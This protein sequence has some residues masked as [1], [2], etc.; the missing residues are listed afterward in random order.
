MSMK[1][2]N[3][4]NESNS[5]KTREIDIDGRKDRIRGATWMAVC[6]S[7]GAL[8]WILF[9]YLANRPIDARDWVLPPDRSLRTD[10]DLTF[11]WNELGKEG[12]FRAQGVLAGKPLPMPEGVVYRCLFDE[13]NLFQGE[14]LFF[15]FKR[16]SVKEWRYR[17]KPNASYEERVAIL[18]AFGVDPFEENLA[19]DRSLLQQPFQIYLTEQVQI[20]SIEFPRAIR[21]ALLNVL[22]G[23]RY[24]DFV[25]MAMNHPSMAAPLLPKQNKADH[26]RTGALHHQVQE[27][28][29]LTVMS[30]APGVSL[31]W[32]YSEENRWIESLNVDLQF[33][34]SRSF[35]GNMQ[36]A[37]YSLAG[38]M[39]FSHHEIINED[40]Y[41]IE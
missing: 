35:L 16:E 22:A 21:E 10:F 2:D 29:P 6:F 40:R 23:K 12:V 33:Q 19:E 17:P 14:E 37:D 25:Q 38:H 34:Q 11:K 39:Q 7:I 8:F 13:L 15:G 28:E 24:S 32:R 1:F 36:N 18:E 41:A 26:W 5:S 30:R 9:F 3:S 20:R 31:V 4:E 27:G